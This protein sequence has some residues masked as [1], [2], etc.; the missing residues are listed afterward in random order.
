MELELEVLG[1][2]DAVISLR[3]LDDQA[4][5]IRTLRGALR[6]AAKPAIERAKQLVPYDSTGDDSYHLR[7]TIGLRAESKKNR[8]GNATIMRFGAHRQTLPAG[9]PSG[10]RIAGGL[11][12]SVRA[13]NYAQLVNDDK[14]FLEPAVEQT[15]PQMLAR[16][17]E[18]LNKQIAKLNK[19]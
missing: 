11:G 3:K 6:F 9:D 12:K 13:P 14:P 4:T 15:L 17:A 10:Y 8:G 1:L 2:D 5:N 18:K 19:P 7:D 16:F